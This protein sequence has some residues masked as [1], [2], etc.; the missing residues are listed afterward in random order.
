MFRI[1]W[2]DWDGEVEKDELVRDDELVDY[3]RDDYLPFWENFGGEIRVTSFLSSWEPVF[4][5]DE[6]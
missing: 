1:T 4:D 5:E 6:N 2:V 3:I